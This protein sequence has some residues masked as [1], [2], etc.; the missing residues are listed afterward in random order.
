MKLKSLFKTFGLVL[1]IVLIATFLDWLAHSSRVEFYV[2]DE[3]FRNK[4]IF[5]TLFGCIS[6]YVFRK[7]KSQTRKALFFSAV[8]AILLQVKYFL[9]GYNLFFVFLFLVLHF[10]MILAPAWYFFRKYP[11][12]L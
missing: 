8:I 12:F 4:I 7:V 6:L 3:Y 2:P 10:L 11:R 9:Q 5:A 1:C